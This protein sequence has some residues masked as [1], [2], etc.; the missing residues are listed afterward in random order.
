M[1]YQ[2]KSFH[3]ITVNGV[4]HLLSN[5]APVM[6]EISRMIKD[7]GILSFTFEEEKPDSSD[8]YHDFSIDG[9]SEKINGKSGVKSYR[10]SVD[11]IKNLL[12]INQFVLLKELEFLAFRA[13]P[14]DK[15][16]HFQAYI[17][18]KINTN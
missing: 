1:P 14:W 7:E 2:D 16:K 11:Y 13:S 4:F 15:E 17:A 5:L 10:H 8:G 3:H 18:K 12:K 6:G 9:I